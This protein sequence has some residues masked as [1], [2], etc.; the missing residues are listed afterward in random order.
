MN[1]Q[2]GKHFSSSLSCRQTHGRDCDQTAVCKPSLGALWPFSAVAAE[3]GWR[4]WCV[5]GGAM[6][7]YLGLDFEAHATLVHHKATVRRVNQRSKFRGPELNYWAP[8]VRQ[9][10]TLTAGA[11]KMFAFFLFTQYAVQTSHSSQ[12]MTV[13]YFNWNLFR[14]LFSVSL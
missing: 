3:A 7:G 8:V 11:P 14:E 9:L 5:W 1:I 12:N 6:E 10:W 13:F 4:H 2:N